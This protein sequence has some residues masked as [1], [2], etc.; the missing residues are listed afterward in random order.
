MS[1]F[2]PGIPYVGYEKITQIDPTKSYYLGAIV[3]FISMIFAYNYVLSEPSVYKLDTTGCILDL[4]GTKLF[5]GFYL[6]IL[7]A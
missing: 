5:Y 7:P 6:S 2:T 3:F 4:N 1:F